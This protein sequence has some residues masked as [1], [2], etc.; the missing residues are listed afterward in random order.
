MKQQQVFA[1]SFTLL[2]ASALAQGMPQIDQ[3]ASFPGQLA[4]LAISF[5]LLY[6]LVSTF[7]APRVSGVLAARRLAISEAIAKAEAL[8]ATAAA[9]RGDFESAGAQARA[10]AAALIAAAQAD[11]ATLATQAQ[12]T[13]ATELQIKAEAAKADIAKAVAAAQANMDDAAAS[14]SASMVSK[15][16]GS[17]PAAAKPTKKAS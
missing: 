6:L 11:T 10:K 8:K 12:A 3:V 4:W 5:V 7:I 17:A 9:T 15:L 2:P 16:L 1:A 13:L 14:L